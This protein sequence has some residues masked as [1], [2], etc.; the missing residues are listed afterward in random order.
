MRCPQCNYRLWNLTARACPECGRPF[1]PSEFEF[2]PNTVE[3]CCPHCGQPHLGQGVLGH[4]VPERITCAGCRRELHM[5]QMVL[6]PVPGVDEKRTQ[7]YLN[8]WFELHERIFFRRYLAAV[9]HGIVRPGLAASGV[10]SQTTYGPS[11]NFLIINLCLFPFISALSL[12]IFSLL[13]N[14]L[15]YGRWLPSGPGPDLLLL[16]SPV[17]FTMLSLMTGLAFTVVWSTSIQAMLYLTGCRPH[18]GRMRTFE[19]LAITSGVHVFTAIP[20]IGALLSVLT[21]PAWIVAAAIA[22]RAV[23]ATP[24]IRT[25]LATLALPLLLLIMTI[26]LVLLA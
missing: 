24:P 25:A 22:V 20:V 1:K 3:F 9:W 8:P 21:I 5:D 12:L 6:R 23:Q 26:N 16:A 17:I 14:L 18:T 19:A 4:L 2:R 11:A 10:P 7:F 13:V 15:R